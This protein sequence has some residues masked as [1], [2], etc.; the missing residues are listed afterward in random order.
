M[1]K[2]IIIFLLDINRSLWPYLIEFIEFPFVVCKRFMSTV[3]LRLMMYEYF[4][5]SLV[6]VNRK[7]NFVKP[8]VEVPIL[9]TGHLA[10]VHSNNEC[11]DQTHY[12]Q[13]AF[14][15]MENQTF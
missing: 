7:L 4:H 2:G 3:S 9:F 14:S 11:F 12:R 6:I 5:H 13:Q 1:V 8:R 10:I 15:K